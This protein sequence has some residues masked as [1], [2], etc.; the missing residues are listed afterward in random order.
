MDY[1][2]LSSIS[3]HDKLLIDNGLKNYPSLIKDLLYIYGNLNIYGNI[4]LPQYTLN[5][6][7]GNSVP[8]FLVYNTSNNALIPHKLLNNSI[9]NYICCYPL[10]KIISCYIHYR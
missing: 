4:N 8:N 2:F 9:L 7:L 1:A 10:V 6:G 5:D 3:Y